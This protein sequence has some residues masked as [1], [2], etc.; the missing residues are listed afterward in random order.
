MKRHRFF[1]RR[2][3]KSDKV[4]YCNNDNEKNTCRWRNDGRTRKVGGMF[5]DQPCL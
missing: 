3:L 4:R 2:I 1:G 5:V